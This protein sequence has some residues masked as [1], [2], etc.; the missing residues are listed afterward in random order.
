MV[1]GGFESLLVAFQADETHARSRNQ[2]EN[3][4][5]HAKAGAEDG[6]ED[7]IAAQFVSL[8]FGKRSG[9]GDRACF[10]RARGFVNHQRG[11][12]GKAAPKV[13]GFGGLIAQPAKVVL[14]QRMRDDGDAVH[15]QWR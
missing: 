12:L 7:D 1:D 9:D 6:H 2:V 3:R 5:E 14:H 15:V 13:L 11:D 4:V 10:E 8:C